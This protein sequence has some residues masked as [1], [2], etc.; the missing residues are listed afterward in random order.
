[1]PRKYLLP[2]LICFYILYSHPVNAFEQATA[3]PAETRQA[4]EEKKVPSKW[5]V[6]DIKGSYPEGAQAPGLFGDI[7]E[8]LA[9]LKE[10]LQKAA[11]DQNIQGVV[12][13]I[14]N[15]AIGW[16]TVSEISH[17]IRKVQSSGKKVYA[18]LEQATTMDYLLASHCDK[19]LMPET[20]MILIPGI[21]AEVTFYKNML[22]KL[23]IQADV[24]RVGKYKAAAENLTRTDMSPEFREEL[25]S[26]LDD[27]YEYLVETIG[28]NRKL[29][30]E[31]VKKIAVFSFRAMRIDDINF[32]VYKEDAVAT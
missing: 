32:E 6:I 29:D 27:H 9:K 3:T 15:P 10:R 22:D 4:A 23:N 12:L 8:S 7:V 11:D 25:T 13:N 21:R 30:L 28:K 26:V 24:M 20:G 2:A 18:Y 5:A 17:S 14:Q 19:I 16:A 1:M 31:K